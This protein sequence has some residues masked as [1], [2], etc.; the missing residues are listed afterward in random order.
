M[1]GTVIYAFISR[2]GNPL[3]NIGELSDQALRP[4][5][6]QRANAGLAGIMK[7]DQTRW[8]LTPFNCE[9]WPAV[10]SRTMPSVL[11]PP[12]GQGRGTAWTVGVTAP[13]PAVRGR[14]FS[15]P[16]PVRVSRDTRVHGRAVDGGVLVSSL[17][18]CVLVSGVVLMWEESGL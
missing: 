11:S 17:A 16:W 1:L 4:E 9:V 7:H 12:K 10:V 6:A 18:A 15:C 3:C 5:D 13:A 14:A 8:W 2:G